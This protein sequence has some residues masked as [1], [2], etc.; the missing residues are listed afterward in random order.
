M[1][2]NELLLALSDMMDTKLKPVNDR[3]EKMEDTLENNVVPRLD[4]LEQSYERLE[5]SH[6][7]L[8]QSHERL[9]QSHKRLEQSF[10][11]L[12]QS[13]EKLEQSQ[14][15]MEL[16]LENN[17]L[18]RLQ[19]IEECYLSTFDRYQSG[20]GQ[21]K[22]MQNDIDVLNTTVRKHSEMFQKMA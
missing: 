1:S 12:E 4:S 9:E 8:E 18:P 15:K 14:K 2:D 21:I 19:T 5:Q 16:T 13:Y 10:E 6:K 3:L 17:I 11:R 22:M 7:R 20:I